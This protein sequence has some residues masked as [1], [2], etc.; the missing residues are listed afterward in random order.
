MVVVVVT[1]AK[2]QR[3]PWA[4]FFH[5]DEVS[6]LGALDWTTVHYGR[7]RWHALEDL[8]TTRIS[9]HTEPRRRLKTALSLTG[10]VST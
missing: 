5:M 6:Y 9:S 3:K 1:K 2:L 7:L 4:S 10:T 8:N